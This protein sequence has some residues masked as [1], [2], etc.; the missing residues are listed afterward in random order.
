MEVR[1]GKTA[2]HVLAPPGPPWRFPAAPAAPLNTH[3]GCTRRTGDLGRWE[4]QAALRSP[5]DL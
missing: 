1:T 3:H 2:V 5:A 4:T